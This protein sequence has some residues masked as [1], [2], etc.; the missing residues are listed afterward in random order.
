M[1]KTDIMGLLIDN[2]DM[3]GALSVASEALNQSIGLTVFTPNAE[4]ACAC[5]NDKEL[6]HLINSAGLILPDG[7]GVLLAAKMLG[8][9]LKAKVAG[10]D[11][12]EKLAKICA[13]RGKSLYILGGK[14]GVAGKAAENLAGKY[15]G[16]KIAGFH[17]GYFDKSDDGSTEITD[18]INASGADVLFVCLGFPAQEKWISENIKNLPNVKIAACLGGSVDIY[19]GKTR[20]A[21]KLFISLRLEWLWRLFK[22]P[23]RLP[24]MMALP[25]YLRKVAAYKKQHK[26]SAGS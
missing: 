18:I 21:P 4:I 8:T 25:E 3:S 19:S 9:P 15:S 24:R 14:P 13:E 6:L 7:A 20:R 10:V 2:V 26:N 22:N 17:D 16:L 11:F 12:G 1:P 5:A 23:S